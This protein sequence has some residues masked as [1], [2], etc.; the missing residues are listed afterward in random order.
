MNNLC[1]ELAVVGD[2]K[3]CE[4]PQPHVLQ[5][6]ESKTI[7]ANIKARAEPNPNPSPQP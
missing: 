5:P 3:L 1:L 6:G 2:L 7:K 4:R